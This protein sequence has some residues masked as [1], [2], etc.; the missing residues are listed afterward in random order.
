MEHISRE[1]LGKGRVQEEP[2]CT[3]TGLHRPL[4]YALPY[5]IQG[6]RALHSSFLLTWVEKVHSVYY[7]VAYFITQLGCATVHFAPP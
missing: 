4:P 2:Y 6:S 3:P 5:G 7:A 1:V